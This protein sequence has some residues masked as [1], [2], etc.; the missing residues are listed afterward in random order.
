MWGHW[1][2]ASHPLLSSG[3]RSCILKS[4]YLLNWLCWSQ[5]FQKSI[6]RPLWFLKWFIDIWVIIP[7]NKTRSVPRW[8]TFFQQPVCFSRYQNSAV[9]SGQ[10]SSL[11]DS[12]VL[13]NLC[14]LHLH[15]P[16]QTAH[17][18]AQEGTGVPGALKRTT[19]IWC[20]SNDAD[21]TTE[22]IVLIEG[23]G[24]R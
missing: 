6:F 2:N 9:T 8:P 23:V 1:I 16:A 14:A 24:M 4:D 22:R 13:V 12:W 5:C 17:P 7:F 18:A 15:Q 20:V 3:N 19:S 10:C 11:F 21:E